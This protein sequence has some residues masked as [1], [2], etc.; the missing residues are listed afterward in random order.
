MTAAEKARGAASASLPTTLHPT[1]VETIV[2]PW[3]T[4]KTMA[5]PSVSGSERMAAVSLY[6]KPGQGHARHNH[7]DSEQIIHVVSGTADMMIEHVEGK[8]VLTRLTA[9]STVTIPQGAFHSTFNVGWDPVQILAIYSPPGPE[10]A[11]KG[12]REFV[13][14]PVGVLPSGK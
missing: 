1:E 11:M 4:A 13:T 7:P 3:V 6:F 5:A 2:A 14:L 10:L 9:G 12:A 8:P